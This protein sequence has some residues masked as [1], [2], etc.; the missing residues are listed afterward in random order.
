MHNHSKNNTG[1]AEL[2]QLWSKFRRLQR[3]LI[4]HSEPLESRDPEY[5]DVTVKCR[6]VLDEFESLYLQHVQETAE[7]GYC[8]SDDD[9]IIQ[10]VVKEIKENNKTYAENFFTRI[11][12]WMK[13]GA[14]TLVGIVGIW[15]YINQTNVREIRDNTDK[16]DVILTELMH[17]KDLDD[18]DT[19]EIMDW[20]STIMDRLE[21]IE[22][23]IEDNKI[24]G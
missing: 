5:A 1:H 15:G 6:N 18:R 8:E 14:L 19:R 9:A 22:S 2:S 17:N 21:S 7:L 23:E 10:G 4:K 11:T 12:N 20:L 16:I 24:D 3:E 13:M